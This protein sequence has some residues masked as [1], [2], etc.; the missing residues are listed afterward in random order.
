MTTD[1]RPRIE[2]STDGA[3]LGN[4]GP[5]GWGAILRAGQHE[6]ELSGAEPD[7]TNNRME[8]TAAIR[9]LEALKQPSRVDLRTDSTYVRNGIMSWVANWQRNGWRT[10]AKQPVKNA[11][12]WRELVAACERHEVTWHWVK[13]HAGD[14]DNEIADRLASAAARTL[15]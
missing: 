5:G 10:S 9:A 11:D 13:G 12:L 2:I 8:L 4:P 1:D 15:L 7:T 3:C 14:R 6:K